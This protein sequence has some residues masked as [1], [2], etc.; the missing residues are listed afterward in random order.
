MIRRPTL[1][2]VVVF[3]LL[4]AVLVFWQ[5]SQE[6]KPPEPTATS[7]Q[8]NLFDPDADVVSMRLQKVGGQVVE[9]QRD[10]QG[11]WELTWPEG[12][13]T[14]VDAV[15]SAVTQLLS[16]RTLSTMQKVPD[17]EVIGLDPPAYRLLLTL[18]DGQQITINV[19][20]ATP[21]A[22]GY[23]VLVSGRPLYVV[24][25]FGLETFLELADSPP[26]VPEP[27]PGPEM[28]PGVPPVTATP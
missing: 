16:L 3:A 13:E 9:L 5:R 11:I 4:V 19:G 6:N 18:S 26:I 12:E 10:D 14:D 21:T 17:L 1:V 28:M 7:A 15:E 24:S 2:A 20:S 22:S 25:K 8:T 23:Y 27:T